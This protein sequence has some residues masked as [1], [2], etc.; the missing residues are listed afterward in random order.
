MAKTGKG[1]PK[2]NA[3][4]NTGVSTSIS[5]PARSQSRVLISPEERHRFIAEAA[6]FRAAERGFQGGDPVE[7]WLSAEAEINRV[8]P[9][10]RDDR[11]GGDAGAGD[12]QNRR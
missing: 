4:H 7:D 10:P 11:G 6:Y 9:R 1:K 3:L 5:D 2:G 8:L 12:K